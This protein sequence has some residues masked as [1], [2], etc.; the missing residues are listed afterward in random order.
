MRLNSVHRSFSNLVQ[1]PFDL[2]SPAAN[3]VGFVPV[4]FSPPRG[5]AG[6]DNSGDAFHFPPVRAAIT[7]LQD[8]QPSNAEPFGYDFDAGHMP[9]DR[10]LHP[11]SLYRTS[12]RSIIAAALLRVSEQSAAAQQPVRIEAPLDVL[13][14]L[15]LIRR[16]LDG[17]QVRLALAEA[18][19]GGDRAP[20]RDCFARQAGHHFLAAL[21]FQA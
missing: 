7:P 9:D 17:Q 6:G 3:A 5:A 20:Q 16:V 18:V 19:L 4:D 10:K 14:R 1:K 21:E 2:P 11:S 8:L 13:H 12:S 15:N